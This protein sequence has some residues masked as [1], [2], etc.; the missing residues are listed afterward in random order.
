MAYETWY[1]IPLACTVWNCNGTLWSELGN[2]SESYTGRDIVFYTETHESPSVLYHPSIDMRGSQQTTR[3]LE[4][5]EEYVAQEGLLSFSNQYYSVPS[6]SSN[7]IPTH[8]S[9]GFACGIRQSRLSL[10][11]SSRGISICLPSLSSLHDSNCPFGICD[12]L[13]D[14]YRIAA[15]R[16][17]IYL[18]AST[19]LSLGSD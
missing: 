9:F 3:R 16:A 7:V 18:H 10:Y 8:V 17:R 14:D 13:P 19:G 4:T 12:S 5:R 1:T 15:Y 6:L 2:F 11:A